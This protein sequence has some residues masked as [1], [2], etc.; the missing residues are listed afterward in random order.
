MA[1]EIKA[2]A[3]QTAEATGEIR[4]KIEGIQKSTQG[5][6]SHIA[7]IAKV[8]DEVNSIVSTIATAIGEQSAATREIASNGGVSAVQLHRGGQIDGPGDGSGPAAGQ[9]TWPS[10]R[11]RNA[12][13][14]ESLW[15]YPA[16]RR[17]D[18][19]FDIIV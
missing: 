11:Y 12:P 3:K 15:P 10:R 18:S 14:G 4:Q 13:L 17:S 1:N 2:L 16:E 6:V 5:T 9:K 8:V 7:Q 19:L